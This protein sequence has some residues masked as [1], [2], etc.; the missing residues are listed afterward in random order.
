MWSPYLFIRW[1]TFTPYVTVSEIHISVWIKWH[2]MVHN[3][4]LRWVLSKR[5]SECYIST[6]GCSMLPVPRTVTCSLD[7]WKFSVFSCL[8]QLQFSNVY[9]SLL[10]NTAQG[11]MCL[12]AWDSPFVKTELYLT[13]RYKWYEGVNLEFLHSRQ[14]VNETISLSVT[15]FAHLNNIYF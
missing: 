2:I 3:E 4:P 13:A 15:P 1:L 5:S 8:S 6:C 10:S 11:K 7:F 14:R 12:L 9:V